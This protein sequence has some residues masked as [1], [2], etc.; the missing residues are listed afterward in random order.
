MRNN[1]DDIEDEI[2]FDRDTSIPK[3]KLKYYRRFKRAQQQDDLSNQVDRILNPEKFIK[4]KSSVMGKNNN[5]IN[6][7]K[8]MSKLQRKSIKNNNNNKGKEELKRKEKEKNEE[9]Q[10]VKK[11]GKDNKRESIK[12]KKDFLIL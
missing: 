4:R 10:K 6:T 3:N 2:V 9:N 12:R 5:N 11:E 7:K 8:R 1:K